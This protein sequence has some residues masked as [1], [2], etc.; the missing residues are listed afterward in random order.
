MAPIDVSDVERKMVCIMKKLFI[1]LP[2]LN[3]GGAER[4]ITYLCQYL[5]RSN[6]IITLVLLQKRGPW[7]AL[8]PPDV[9]II[10]LHSNRLQDALF[11][12]IGVLHKE[13]P[14]I[15][16]STLT[17]YNICLCFLHIFFTK[18]KLVIRECNIVSLVLEKKWHKVLY[19]LVIGIADSIVCQS[20]DMMNDLIKNFHGDR[21]KMYK[22]NN[23][24]NFEFLE[25]KMQEPLSFSFMKNKKIL[26]AVGRLEYQK[27]FDLL[28]NTFSKLSNK[29]DFQ[30]IILGIGSLKDTLE[31]QARGLKISHLVSFPGFIDNPYI[32]MT[33]ADFFI[34]SSRFEGF[35]NAVIEAL[36]CGLPVIANDYLGG[37]NE[38][39]NEETGSI[40][41]ITN[42]SLLQNALMKK[43]N[44]ERIKA[45]CKDKYD[46]AVIIRK[47]ESIF[48]L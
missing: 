43:Y 15:V 9:K 13:K 17:H 23:P 27:G 47:Y 35:P 12:I 7:L 22:I 44:S 16:V 46:L 39:V 10:D 34:S 37:I 1:F 45:Y 48:N 36:A 38:I 33:K 26:I 6:F 14:D 18:F 31:E 5:D 24:V 30:L 20:D 11:S 40:I 25:K 28:I 29:D 42:V 41:D 19:S 4:V 21:K 3:G 8:I 2:S 32:Y